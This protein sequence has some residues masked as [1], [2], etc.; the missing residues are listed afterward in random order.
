MGGSGC[1]ETKLAVV[2]RMDERKGE[3]L[4]LG[5]NPGSEKPEPG[6]GQDEGQ[7]H[8]PEITDSGRHPSFQS[9]FSKGPNHIYPPTLDVHNTIRHHFL[10]HQTKLKY[11]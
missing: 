3:K 4:E 8:V 1:R 10:K 9:S 5:N 2:P 6:A 11:V 7:G